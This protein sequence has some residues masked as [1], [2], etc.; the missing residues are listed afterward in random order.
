MS[1]KRERMA[2]G[3]TDGSEAARSSR[4]NTRDGEDVSPEFESGGCMD[5]QRFIAVVPAS[6][7]TA[8][9]SAPT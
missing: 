9:R 4:V 3:R 8:L 1:R 7:T 2:E 5:N 6:R